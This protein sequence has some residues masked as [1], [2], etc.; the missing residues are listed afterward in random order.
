[1]NGGDKGE[2]SVGCYIYTYMVHTLYIYVMDII[3]REERGIWLLLLLL[4]LEK[5][6]MEMEAEAEAEAT[7]EVGH[8]S[9]AWS[10]S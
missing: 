4:L 9:V 2:I 7:E 3:C 5:Q 8:G 6:G 10:V 1:M